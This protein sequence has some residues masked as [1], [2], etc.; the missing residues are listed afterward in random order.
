MNADSSRSHSIFTI[1]IEM[2]SSTG[3]G[4]I[5]K[6]KL[7]LV[8]LAGSERQAKTGATGNRLKEATKINL[9]LSALG[10]VI[11]ALVDGRSSHIP[12]RDSKLTR[13]LQD[14]LGGNAKT[15][16][17][18][19]FGPSKFNYDETLTTLRYANRAK[20]IKNKPK[21]NEDPKDAM[22]REFQE[23]I[24]RLKSQLSNKKTDKREK[25][26]K[27]RKSAKRNSNIIPDSTM[28]G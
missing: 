24:A 26:A 13:L 5:R 22:L 4:Q 1:N 3:D 8:D 25:S 21:I 11:S 18:A 16:M 14:S 9:S 7:N 12:Y 23:E 17:V 28:P 27:R 20:N 15:I 19:N 6:G 10:N 2:M